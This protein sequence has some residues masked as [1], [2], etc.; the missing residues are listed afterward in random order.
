MR[1]SGSQ[2]EWEKVRLIA[3]NMFEQNLKTRV[4]VATLKV[5]DQTDRRWRR[6]FNGK[7]RL[8]LAS[9][10]HNGRRY[11]MNAGQKKQQLQVESHRLHGLRI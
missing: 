1:R 4:I 3:A 9:V 8:G 5:D 11:R 6:I 2:S 7:G 10:K